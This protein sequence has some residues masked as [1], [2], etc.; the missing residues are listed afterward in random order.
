V[1]IGIMDNAQIT[2]KEMKR[3]QHKEIKDFFLKDLFD[4]KI[5]KGSE[6]PWRN[7]K[8][9]RWMRSHR[10]CISDIHT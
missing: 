10:T 2:E 7:G 5:F 8:N 4:L 3:M 1:K 9:Q 6:D